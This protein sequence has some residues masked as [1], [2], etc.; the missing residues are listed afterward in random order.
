MG[1]E[2]KKLAK[3]KEYEYPALPNINLA[4]LSFRQKIKEME[5]QKI[6]KTQITSIDN[7]PL[8]EKERRNSLNRQ[9]PIK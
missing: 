9:S 3:M 7:S 8:A 5:I 1:E 2:I 4:K 6:N